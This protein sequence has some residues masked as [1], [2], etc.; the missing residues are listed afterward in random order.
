VVYY[1]HYYYYHQHHHK[2]TQHLHLQISSATLKLEMAV[3]S[4]SNLPHTPLSQ[5]LVSKRRFRQIIY[6]RALQ[7]ISAFLL[8]EY[9]ILQ[10]TI[11]FTFSL[12]RTSIFIWQSI[13]LRPNNSSKNL[14]SAT[15]VLGYLSYW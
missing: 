6:F 5:R 9:H 14:I 15:L 7:A 1:Y 3:T 11:L 10:Y 8:M 13:T 2:H 12:F 4:F